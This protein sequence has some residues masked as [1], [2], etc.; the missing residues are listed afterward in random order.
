MS[1]YHFIMKNFQAIQESA[2]GAP[3]LPYF[4]ENKLFRSTEQYRTGQE[5]KTAAG[6]PLDAQLFLAVTPPWTDE[7]IG[8]DVSVDIGRAE[9][10]H[11]YV[12]NQLPYTLNGTPFESKSQFIQGS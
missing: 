10:E 1:K 9:L 6:L 4:V 7:E 3:N 8:N 12:K 5:I 11:F 2:G